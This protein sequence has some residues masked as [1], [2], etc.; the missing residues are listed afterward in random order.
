MK[1]IVGPGSSF[2]SP[3]F[4]STLS[5]SEIVETW[6]DVGYGSRVMFRHE[7]SEGGYLHSHPHFYPSGSKQQQITCYPHKVNSCNN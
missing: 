3:E 5:G 7:G 1:L 6:A 4:Q 2:M